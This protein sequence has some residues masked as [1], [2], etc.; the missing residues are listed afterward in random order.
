MSSIVAQKKC[1]LKKSPGAIA[2]GNVG[3]GLFVFL[4][5]VTEIILSLLENAGAKAVLFVILLLG[6]RSL[7]EMRIRDGIS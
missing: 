1:V 2:D 5:H 3:I 7:C 6:R 4:K